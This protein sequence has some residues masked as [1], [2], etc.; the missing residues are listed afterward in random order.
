MVSY[1]LLETKFFIPSSK[2]NLVNR[3]RLYIS[4][5]TVK[6]HTSNIY[7]KLSVKNRNQAVVKARELEILK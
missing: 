7:G 4:L 2:S 5:A 6:W 1:D 3:D